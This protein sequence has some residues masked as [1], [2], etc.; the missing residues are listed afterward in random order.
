MQG[1][2]DEAGIERTWHAQRTGQ[3][4][5]PL[6][7]GQ[8]RGNR[9]QV[10]TATAAPARQV[11]DEYLP[12]GDHAEQL[13]FRRPLPA[14]HTGTDRLQMTRPMQHYLG[15]AQRDSADGGAAGGGGGGGGG[16]L[17]GSTSGRMSIRQPV[18]RAARRAFCPSR[19]IA[20][21]SW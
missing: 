12:V 8:T 5:A 7:P 10:G 2:V 19:P 4:P 17:S 21:E 3:H 9:M 20:S 13:G 11:R 6:G 14:P 16:G 15:G 18:S 1:G